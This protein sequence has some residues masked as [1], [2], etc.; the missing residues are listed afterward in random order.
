MLTPHC[1]LID[2]AMLITP[3]LITLIHYFSPRI[4]RCRFDDAASHAPLII[5]ATCRQ[6]TRRHATSFLRHFILRR[7]HCRC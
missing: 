5:A 4:C 7:R 6:I 1:R 2:Y 3:L